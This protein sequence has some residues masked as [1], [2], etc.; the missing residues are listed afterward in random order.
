MK[1][2]AWTMLIVGVICTIGYIAHG[3]T[4]DEFSWLNGW[5]AGPMLLVFFVPSLFRVA[6][7]MDGVS[8][9]GRVH[10]VFRD[11]PIGIGRVVGVARTGLSVNDRPQ[12]EIRLE[13]DTTDGRT[14]P[15]TARE[16]V[17]LTDLAAV[18]VGSTLP[19]RYLPDGRASIAADAPPHVLQ[20]ALD[21]VQLAKGLVTEKQLHIAR[22]GVDAQAVVLAMNPTG[23][24][25]LDRSVVRLA[26]RVTRPDGSRFDVTQEKAVPPTAV[27]QL[28]AGS[29]V[30]VKYLPH[31]ESEVT[32]LTRL[33]P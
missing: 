23:E 31:D 12:L 26:L 19:V 10:R 5:M 3:L 32:V 13:V 16:L 22:A 33:V 17:D 4:G 29:V 14:L 27:P 1:A 15:A 9:S 18:Q 6:R 21:R 30:R 28:Q 8:A 11:A 2:L 24:V 7:M 25:R 20:D